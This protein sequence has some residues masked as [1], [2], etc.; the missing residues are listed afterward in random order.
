MGREPLD[1][2]VP[3]SRRLL[4]SLAILLL[5]APVG[6]VV[7]VEVPLQGVLRDNAGQLVTEGAFGMCKRWKTSCAFV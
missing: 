6:A 2:K 1:L 3:M 5:G 7:P 4:I